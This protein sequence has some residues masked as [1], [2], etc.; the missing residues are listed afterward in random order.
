MTTVMD[1][2]LWPPF[3]CFSFKDIKCL[4]P[5]LLARQSWSQCV[6]SSSGP[7]AERCSANNRCSV[8]TY[9]TNGST[10]SPGSFHSPL[11]PGLRYLFQADWEGGGQA[12]PFPAS[13]GPSRFL[14]PPCSPGSQRYLPET[15]ISPLL[16]ATK[17]EAIEWYFLS[18]NFSK[19]WTM[20]SLGVLR[21]LLTAVCQLYAQVTS[22]LLREI[23]APL[24]VFVA[25]MKHIP[26]RSSP[27]SLAAPTASQHHL[28]CSSSSGSKINHRF[29]ESAPIV[30]DWES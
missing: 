5:R 21:Q 17:F 15:A 8:I 9:G 13:F 7:Q 30:E 14:L 6:P 27:V 12:P 29:R 19:R 1:L 16:F 3:L 10:Q 26:C 24:L 23:I 25:M 4:V 20:Y 11:L 18:L 22:L 2:D 28:S